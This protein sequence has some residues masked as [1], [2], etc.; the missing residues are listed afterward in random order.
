MAHRKESRVRQIQFSC[1][2]FSEARH[3]Q[4]EKRLTRL[5]TDVKSI[6]TPIKHP[7]SIERDE[8]EGTNFSACLF[9]F[10]FI[11]IFI[12]ESVYVCMCECDCV[13]VPSHR[14]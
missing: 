11:Y 1:L 2:L 5:T 14:F 3:S 10:L 8:C 13:Y 4:E 9:L 12:W 7:S 6:L